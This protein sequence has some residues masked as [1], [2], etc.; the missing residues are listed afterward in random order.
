MLFRK[1]SELGNPGMVSRWAAKIY[2]QIKR[3][4]PELSDYEVIDLMLWIRFNAIQPNREQYVASIRA[5]PTIHNILEAVEFIL[6]QEVDYFKN[7]SE[8]IQIMNEVIGDLLCKNGVPHHMVFGTIK[9]TPAAP[10][11]PSSHEI[12]CPYCQQTLRIPAITKKTEFRC[13]S[14]KREFNV[15]P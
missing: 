14:C 13:P 9:N 11:A 2:E 3:E 7:T 5:R 10:P 1:M 8:H 15:N 12:D 4:R 6:D